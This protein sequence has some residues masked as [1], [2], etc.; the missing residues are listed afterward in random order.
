MARSFPVLSDYAKSR[1][2][3]NT[4]SFVFSDRTIEKSYPKHW[5]TAGELIMPLE[6]NYTLTVSDQQYTLHPGE[7][8][9]LPTG[10]LHEVLGPIGGK[11]IIIQF[12]RQTFH[13]AHVFDSIIPMLHPCFII[14]PSSLPDSYSVF[15]S[16]MDSIIAE[17]NHNQSLKDV[18]LNCLLVNFF[19]HLERT[20]L[21][22]I[23]TPTCYTE[24]RQQEYADIVMKLCVYTIDH[25]TENINSDTLVSVTG[26]SKFHFMRI[27]KQM[28]GISYFTYLTTLRMQY[29]KQ[30]LAN[31]TLS[32]NAVAKKSGFQSLST[33]NR[34][35]KLSENYSPTDYRQLILSKLLS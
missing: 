33:F 9:I 32:I 10:E 16:I 23:E 1:V 3:D 31:D 30:L 2:P 18:V 29:A 12:D 25:F 28:I 14:S 26:Y 24:Y 20:L 7:I 8:M 27:F 34:V 5:H 19:V 35:F 6:Q 4:A 15:R 11:R 13:N 21:Q 22:C 17:S